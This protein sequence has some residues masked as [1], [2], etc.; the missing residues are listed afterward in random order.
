MQAAAFADAI[1]EVLPKQ[2]QPVVDIE[3]YPHW[4]GYAQAAELIAAR[5]GQRYKID[6]I[7][8]LVQ[9]KKLT[10][11]PQIEGRVSRESCL[12]FAG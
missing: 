4:L 11:H 1:R 5:S 2:P 7:R 10:P 6:S 12:E 8:K 3:S 9:R